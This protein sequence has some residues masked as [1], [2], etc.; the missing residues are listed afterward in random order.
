MK[1]KRKNEKEESCQVK[2]TRSFHWPPSPAARRAVLSTFVMNSFATEA[3]KKEREENDEKNRGKRTVCNSPTF[4]PF[5]FPLL[6]LFRFKF[7]ASTREE[8]RKS[9]STPENPVKSVLAT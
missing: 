4:R 6:L 2:E 1:E 9:R 8:K 5:K 3:G 7:V